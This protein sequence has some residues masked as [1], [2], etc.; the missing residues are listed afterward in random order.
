M[1]SKNNKNTNLETKLEKDTQSKHDLSTNNLEMNLDTNNSDNTSDNFIDN[2]LN[3]ALNIDEQTKTSTAK[4]L[5]KNNTSK[6]KSKEVEQFEKELTSQE[7]ENY[8]DTTDD[9]KDANNQDATFKNKDN[10]ID[11]ILNQEIGLTRKPEA[12]PSQDKSPYLNKSTTTE[13]D[14]SDANQTEDR[15]LKDIRLKDKR[16]IKDLLKKQKIKEQINSINALDLK[17]ENDSSNKTS[18]VDNLKESKQTP[19]LNVN[20]TD[21]INEKNISE[22]SYTNNNIHIDKQKEASAKKDILNQTQSKGSTIAS[23][24]IPISIN[25]KDELNLNTTANNQLNKDDDFNIDTIFKDSQK[26]KTESIHNKSSHSEESEKE[27]FG[28]IINDNITPK[29]NDKPISLKKKPQENI[30]KIEEKT[31]KEIADKNQ[32][33]EKTDLINNKDISTKAS[34]KT[35]EP[36]QE[37]KEETV[38]LAQKATKVEPLIASENIDFSNLYSENQ[39]VK[40]FNKTA[41]NKKIETTKKSMF[42]HIF[43]ALF[44]VST[45]SLT[46]LYLNK[47]KESNKIKIQQRNQE[48][49]SIGKNIQNIEE[50]SKTLEKYVEL[51]QRLPENNKDLNPIS[52]NEAKEKIQQSLENNLIFNT[53]INISK[54]VILSGIFNKD[55]VLV[56]S[57]AITIKY[58]AIFDGSIFSFIKELEKE[59]PGYIIV[60]SINF[61][62]IV[63]N[64]TKKILHDIS[65]GNFVAIFKGEIKIYWFKIDKKVR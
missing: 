49:E 13:K 6:K 30:G 57:T 16:K 43:V 54:P 20:S 47:S 31:Q 28:D 42:I 45:C 10:D 56:E 59:M 48:L 3:E 36:I 26:V 2:I 7:Y 50:R 37:I 38:E 51:W 44:F 14:S 33:V 9:V 34:I 5:N 35:T 22:K 64:I 32:T 62:K 61:E 18:K 12:A 58:D 65:K 4:T 41:W 53:E 15:K 39:E 40:K 24:D 23:Q 25:T 52:I 60:E 21:N 19:E 46:V 8:K 1:E 55:S 29:I 63:K 11:N 17:Q 27:L